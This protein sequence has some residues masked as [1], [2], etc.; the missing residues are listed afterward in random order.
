MELIAGR[1]LKSPEAIAK[2]TDVRVKTGGKKEQTTFSTLWLAPQ[3]AAQPDCTATTLSRTPCTAHDPGAVPR[4]CKH[5][6]IPAV[7]ASKTGICQD[8]DTADMSETLTSL[9]WSPEVSSSFLAL[10]AQ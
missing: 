5:D 4:D 7:K 10:T 9:V 3:P 6:G 1:R 2:K 8:K